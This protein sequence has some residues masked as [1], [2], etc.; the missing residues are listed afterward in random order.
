MCAYR[1]WCWSE[2]LQLSCSLKLVLLQCRPLQGP[3]QVGDGVPGCS[4]GEGREEVTEGGR[5]GEE[6]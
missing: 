6:G 4:S 1:V 3:S 5:R 2:G